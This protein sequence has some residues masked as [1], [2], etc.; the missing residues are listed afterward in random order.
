MMKIMIKTMT[1]ATSR[2][3]A[4]ILLIQIFNQSH[5]Y[6]YQNRFEY[7]S[8]LATRLE[9]LLHSFGIAAIVKNVEPGP[10]V[11]LFEIELSL[12][13]SGKELKRP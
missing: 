11:T 4:R 12:G 10:V 6:R 13:V 8:Q 2:W 7:L 9:Q 1:H 5:N 3:V